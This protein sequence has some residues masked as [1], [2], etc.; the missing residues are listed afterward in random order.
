M[1]V[2]HPMAAAV[3]HKLVALMDQQNAVAVS[4]GTL[5]KLLGIHINTVKRAIDAL[6][7]DRWVQVVQL[8]QR[9]TVNAYVVNDQVAWGTNREKLPFSL[10]SAAIV[11]YR[12]DQSEQTLEA[13]QLRRIPVLMKGER[14][15]PTGPGLGPPSEPALPGLEPDLPAR[16]VI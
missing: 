16:K 12:D 2:R 13:K 6:E 7:K 10:F 3:M 15:L 8:G 4:H 1:I 9:G 5:A 14:Q 11:A